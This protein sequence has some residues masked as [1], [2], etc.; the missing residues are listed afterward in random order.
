MLHRGLKNVQLWKN[1]EW[2]EKLVELEERKN[3][4]IS[5]L[6]ESVELKE[7]QLK[8]LME[9]QKKQIVCIKNEVRE[10]TNEIYKK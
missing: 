5:M 7:V 2:K 9:D 10:Q 4:E 6:K 3:K 8:D 1:E